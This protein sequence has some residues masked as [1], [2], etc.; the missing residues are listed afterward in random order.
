MMPVLNA[1]FAQQSTQSVRT[2]LLAM[3]VVL[4]QCVPL[5]MSHERM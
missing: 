3:L 1:G 5:P 2:V 4:A